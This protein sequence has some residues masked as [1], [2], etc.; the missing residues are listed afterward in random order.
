[1]H[2][3]AS[4]TAVPGVGKAAPRLFERATT[5]T[6]DGNKPIR[7]DEFVGRI[8]SQDPRLSVARLWCPAGWAEPTQ[9]PEF[10]EVTLVLS[11]VVRIEHDGQT[12]AVNAGEA[13]VTE[14]GES[15]QYRT[16]PDSDADYIAVCIP[17]FSMD[18][19]HRNSATTRLVVQASRLHDL[20]TWETRMRPLL[21]VALI[22]EIAMPIST[23]AADPTQSAATR[24]LH[25][26]F[27]D[28][29]QRTLREHPTF[30]SELGDLRYN[31]RWD[32][33]SFEAIERSHQADRAA[34]AGSRLSIATP[35]RR[36]IS[37][38]TS[39]PVGVRTLH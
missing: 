34:L 1:M 19:A 6:G 2:R 16:P 14:P 25:A 32:D 4:P 20:A 36:P 26:L 23:A 30:A 5:I 37:S 12:F 7:I 8:N 17:A 15:I 28:E 3:D 24:E 33:V 18:A 38:I 11:G 10:L 31:D 35:F 39:L 27:D 29:W 9:Q 21:F 13:I 22:C